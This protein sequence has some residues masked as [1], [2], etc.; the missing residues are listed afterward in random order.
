MTYDEWVQAQNISP[1]SP[2]AY[3]AELAWNEAFQTALFFVHAGAK[4]EKD[5]VGLAVLLDEEFTHLN[6]GFRGAD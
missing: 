4:V 3:Y 6:T 1:S 5:V 2:E